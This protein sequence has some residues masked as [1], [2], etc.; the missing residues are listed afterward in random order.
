[1]RRFLLL[2]GMLVLPGPAAAQHPDTDATRATLAGVYTA[3]Q[4]SRGKSLYQLN[5]ASCHTAAS[6]AG[7][8]F[9]EMWKGKLLWDL[10]RYVS[11]KMPKSEPG[12]LA[13]GEYASLVAYLL[14]MNDLPAGVN[15]IPADS[16]VL[17]TIRI[18]FKEQRD[19]TQQR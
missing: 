3:A 8:V 4:A 12:S 13:P 9:T 14:K 16:T 11:E 2:G 19:S 17:K 15:E 1:M 5:C 6:H 10:Y 18:V 7:P